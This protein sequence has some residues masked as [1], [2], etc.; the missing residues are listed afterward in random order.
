MKFHNRF[1]PFAHILVGFQ[2]IAVNANQQF[3]LV[4]EWNSS[5]TDISYINQYSTTT[6]ISPDANTSFAAAFGGGL[7]INIQKHISV[8]LFEVEVL[9]S[10]DAPK[11]YIADT[12]LK[13]NNFQTGKNYSDVLKGHASRT[14]SLKLSFG[15]VL[16]VGHHK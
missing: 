7:D 6:N 9:N 2:R 1:K 3:D 16:H 8:R 14:N 10:R 12:I 11:N 4:Q 13:T 5:T 15:A